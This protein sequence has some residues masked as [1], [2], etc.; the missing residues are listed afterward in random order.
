MGLLVILLKKNF[1]LV[2]YYN[3]CDY[4]EFNLWIQLILNLNIALFK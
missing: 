1:N 4:F 2:S 3:A